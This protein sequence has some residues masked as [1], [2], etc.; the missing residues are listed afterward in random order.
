MTWQGMA[1]GCYLVG[2]VNV[3][4]STR[5]GESARA[6]GGLTGRSYPALTGWANVFRTYGAW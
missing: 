2:G 5:A 1:I 6:V 4:G 3:W